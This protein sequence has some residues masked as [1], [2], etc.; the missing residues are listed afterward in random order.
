MRIVWDLHVGVLRVCVCVWLWKYFCKIFIPL[1]R[2]EE[3]KFVEEAIRVDTVIIR[4]LWMEI[5]NDW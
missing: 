5:E 1:L 3:K 4:L 2:E